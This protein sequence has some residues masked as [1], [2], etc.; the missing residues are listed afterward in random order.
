VFYLILESSSNS[1]GAC[2]ISYILDLN[3]KYYL[4]L[5]CLLQSGLSCLGKLFIGAGSN[6]SYY[7]EFLVSF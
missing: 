2:G 5:S 7:Y 1:V 4:F 3:S 6:F